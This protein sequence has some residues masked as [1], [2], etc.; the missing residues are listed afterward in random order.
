V[1]PALVDA[2]RRRADSL[3]AGRWVEA[4]S[5]GHMVMFSE[6]QIV[7]DEILRLLDAMP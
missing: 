6:P 3:R 4:A 5:S 7:I 1:R 2:H